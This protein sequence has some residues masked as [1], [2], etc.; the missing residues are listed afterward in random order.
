MI[1]E[2]CAFGVFYYVIAKSHI[3]WNVTRIKKL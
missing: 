2:V 3:L 1:N